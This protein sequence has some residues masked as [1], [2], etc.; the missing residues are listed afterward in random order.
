ME[1]SE[2]GELPEFPQEQS[3]TRQNTALT[4]V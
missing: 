4:S 1:Q 3:N 2:D